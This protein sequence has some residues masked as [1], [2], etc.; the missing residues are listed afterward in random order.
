MFGVPGTFLMAL[1]L[2]QLPGPAALLS[3][4]GRPQLIAKEKDYFL[5]ALPGA[6]SGRLSTTALFPAHL[7]PSTVYGLILLHTS[8]AT[9]EMK[10][11]AAGGVTKDTTAA[12]FRNNPR[13]DIYRTRIAGVLADKERI[14]VLRWHDSPDKDPSMHL[15]VFR[16]D[17]GEQV[18]SLE[19]KGDAVPQ[20]E[21]EETAKKGPLE[22]RADG[23]ACFGT[24]FEFKGTKLVKQTP[25][26]KP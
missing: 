6:G 4:T 12:R 10:I 20:K 2:A 25:E 13:P 23:V 1:A 11:L 26:I 14:Y 8:T 15:L 16:P 21:P 18:H 24:R 5:H 22:L 3:E 17:T 19:L 9:A 7:E